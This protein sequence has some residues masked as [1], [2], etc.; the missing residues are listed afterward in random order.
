MSAAE[1]K[2]LELYSCNFSAETGAVPMV[3]RSLKDP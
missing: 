2:Q 3:E 1:H